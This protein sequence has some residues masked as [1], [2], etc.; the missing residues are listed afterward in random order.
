M[1]ADDGVTYIIVVQETAGEAVR[2][3]WPA[4]LAVLAACLVAAPPASAAATLCL[5]Q[6]PASLLSQTAHHRRP[7]QPPELPPLPP[8]ARYVRHPNECYDWGTIGWV[9]ATG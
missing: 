7:P 9:F 1:A 8:N 4:A 3:A 5:P 6:L 2:G